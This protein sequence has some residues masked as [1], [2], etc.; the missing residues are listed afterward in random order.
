MPEFRDV[1]TSALRN[2][3]C[4]VLETGGNYFDWLEDLG[5]PGP[6]VGRVPTDVAYRMM[7]NR[8]PPALPAPPFT[9]GQCA[10]EYNVTIYRGLLKNGQPTRGYPD[11]Y[12]VRGFGPVNGLYLETLTNG[13]VALR[14]SWA[15]AQ[16]ALGVAFT[17]QGEAWVSYYISNIARVGGGPDNCGNPPPVIPTPAPNYRTQPIN[18]TYQNNTN[19]NVTLTGNFT[20]AGPT[21]NLNGDI[22]VPVRLNI[23][24][25]TLNIKGEYNVNNTSLSLDFTNINYG[26]GT[27]PNPDS[28]RSPDD[29]P[30]VP[31][32]V[33][34]PVLPPSPNTPNDNSTRVIRAVIVTVT[35]I[36]DEFGVIFQ[37]DN[38]DI[39]IPNLGFVNFQVAVGS[40]VA[41]TVDLPV[42]NKRNLIVCPW[43]GGALA[44]RGTPRSGV[45][46]TLSPVYA[47]ED[48]PVIYD[49]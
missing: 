3:I 17:S 37:D 6:G 40:A 35:E 43:E 33:P 30:T 7:C 45:E 10:Y 36:P 38:P 41:L 46:W 11:F 27:K 34:T 47:I 31:P 18:I 16:P 28:F 42:K 5:V 15:S 23:D 12:T 21:I 20:F 4:S 19:N 8:E 26:P 2:T 25:P 44:V 13:D 48:D 22:I 9:G 49:S 39:F 1:L 14:I 29:T 32:D 24:G